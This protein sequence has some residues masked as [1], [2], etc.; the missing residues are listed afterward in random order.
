MSKICV[1]GSMNV[2]TSMLVSALP[3][4]GET[5]A[6]RSVATSAGGKG[7][8]QAVAMK[9]L[10]S[11][12]SFIGALGADKNGELLRDLLIEENID[13]QFV[14]VVDKMT[15]QAWI[16]IQEN[17]KNTIVTYAGANNAIEVADI[18]RAKAVIEAAAVTV[19]QF[20]VPMATIIAAFNYAK[21][22]GRLTVLNPAPSKA[23]PD[24]LLQVTD[25]LVPNETEIEELLGETFDYS[26]YGRVQ[27][28]LKP[29]FDMGVQYIIVTLGEDGVLVCEPGTC[30][31]VAAFPVKAVDTTAAGDSFIGALVSQI[32]EQP[33]ESL[34]DIIRTANYFASLV[35]Q[36]P[37]A[38]SSIPNEYTLEEIKA[39]AL[40]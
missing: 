34:V 6:G 1:L 40:K 30:S 13:N 12:V 38:Y 20:E 9:R 5:V 33:F 39:L 15:G 25:I 29:L 22:A 35:V 16:T 36:R 31:Q 37:G 19:A 11:E 8:N 27:Q 7:L 4:V 21:K 23:I 24:E 17:G 14:K 28:Q 26:D 2:D 10:G 3:E 32:Y 18:D